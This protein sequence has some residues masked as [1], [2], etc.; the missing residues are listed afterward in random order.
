MDCGQCRTGLW[1]LVDSPS[2]GKYY[3][4]VRG[5]S[6]HQN[7]TETIDGL[8]GLPI[9]VNEPYQYYFFLKNKYRNRFNVESNLRQ[10]LF[11]FNPNINTFVRNKILNFF[12]LL[13]N[14]E[15]LKNPID[16]FTTYF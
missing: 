14:P 13:K 11:M 8:F 10:K 9:Y 2:Q 12:F 4:T 6:D 7:C 1:T 3:R 15:I 5:S 16:I